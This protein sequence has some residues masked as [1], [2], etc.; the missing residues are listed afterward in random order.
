MKLAAILIA[1]SAFAH[2][3]NFDAV[4]VK[5]AQPSPDG[6]VHTHI[7]TD[8]AAGTLEFASV[9]FRE[10]MAEAYHVRHDQIDGPDWIDTGLFDVAAH[11]PPHTSGPRV[12]Q[13]LQTLL[14]DRF[15]LAIHRETKQLAVYNL[16]VAPGGPKFQP[17]ATEAPILQDVP[18]THWQVS[19]KTTMRHFA[20]FMSTD[21]DRPVL[22]HTGLTGS[23]D[24]AL[25]WW[26]ASSH[27]GAEISTALEQR[28]GLKLDPST[29]AVE[30]LHIDHAE[31]APAGD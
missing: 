23:Y 27:S 7:S 28:L 26:S 4:T 29:G 8:T 30:I 21:L 15:K 10:M 19:G 6:Q 20:D 31:R 14:A 3:Q 24:F 18:G 16:V 25:D 1:C 11:F 5:L 12:E 13:M 17:A 9:T 22:D 2:A